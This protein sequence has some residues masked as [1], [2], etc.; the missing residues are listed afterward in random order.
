[1][2][3]RWRINGELTLDTR[4]GAN[5]EAGIATYSQLDHY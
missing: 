3:H 2:N 4:G 5:N 1:M